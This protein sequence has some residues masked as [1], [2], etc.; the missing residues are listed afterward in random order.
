VVLAEVQVDAARVRAR[1]AEHGLLVV[2]AGEVG[3]VRVRLVL[4]ELESYAAYQGLRTALLERVGVRA[5]LPVEMER[6][7]AVLEVDC[8]L[9]EEALLA[10]LLRV[11]PP[12]LEITTV[13]VS[14]PG[15][16]LRVALRTA[17]PAAGSTP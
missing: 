1:L 10:E 11:A 15:I 9:Q 4:E 5:V 14:Q 3:R 8:D 7:R 6:G 12:E 17:P 16:G 2:P 13:T